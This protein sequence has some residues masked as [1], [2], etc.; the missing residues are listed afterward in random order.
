MKDD[1]LIAMME[2]NTIIIVLIMGFQS[3]TA[4]DHFDYVGAL[5]TSSV[6]TPRDIAKD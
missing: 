6:H 4:S 5:T 3:I 1:V 2:R